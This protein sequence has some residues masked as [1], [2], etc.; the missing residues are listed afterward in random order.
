MKQRVNELSLV[1]FL[2]CALLACDPKIDF[3]NID[4]SV[5]AEMGIALPVGEFGI[6]LGDLIPT[7][8]GVLSDNEQG[9]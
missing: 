8:E 3:D 4:P 2:A 6:T 5:K 1:V 7:N 9:V